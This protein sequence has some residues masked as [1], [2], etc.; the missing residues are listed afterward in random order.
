MIHCWK[1]LDVMNYVTFCWMTCGFMRLAMLQ[2]EM[3]LQKYIIMGITIF[4]I[5]IWGWYI[6]GY[7]FR[8]HVLRLRSCF[9][10]IKGPCW[11]LYE[12]KNNQFLLIGLLEQLPNTPASNL[13]YLAPPPGQFFI[14]AKLF[15]GTPWMGKEGVLKKI[16]VWAM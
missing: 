1:L 11:P 10:W 4:K 7:M 14:G 15:I 6:I 9:L 12:P 8:N 13:G 2:F 16:L 3:K 5:F